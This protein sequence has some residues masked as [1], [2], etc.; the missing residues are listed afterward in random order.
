MKS[1]YDTR[2]Y[3][4][5]LGAQEPHLDLVSSEIIFWKLQAHIAFSTKKNTFSD[6]VLSFHISDYP[7]VMAFHSAAGESYA[8]TEE[9]SGAQRA[10]GASGH[11]PEGLPRR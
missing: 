7:A 5:I 11:I 9:Q 10:I 8:A 6:Q 3:S 1:W 4:R 2:H